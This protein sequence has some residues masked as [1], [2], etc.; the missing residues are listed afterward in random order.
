MGTPAAAAG[1]VG[2]ISVEAGGVPP[3][4]ELCGCSAGWVLFGVGFLFWPCWVAAAFLP[5]C[6]KNR[7][8][9]LAGIASTIGMFVLVVLGII[10]GVTSPRWNGW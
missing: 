8:D 10:L 5:L 1:P 7:S 2:G 6:T 4:Q 3:G 9:R